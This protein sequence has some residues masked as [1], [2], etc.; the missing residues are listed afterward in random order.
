MKLAYP[1][2]RFS[3]DIQSHGDSARRQ[4]Q[5]V[6]NWA[7]QH[8]D[9]RLSETAYTDEGLSA[10][11]GKHASAELGRLMSDIENG[12]I[13]PSDCILI[14]SLDRL[15]REDIQTASERLKAIQVKGVDVVTLNDET[16][17]TVASLNDSFTLIKQI[18]ISQRAHEESEAKSKRMLQVW[19]EKRR[20]AEKSG[21]VI[22]RMCP[23]W[24]KANKDG[25]GFDVIH[26][27]VETL[28][29]M[30]QLRV[31]GLGFTRITQIL[32]ETGRLTFRDN[33]PNKWQQ[34]RVQQ[35]ISSRAVIGYHIKSRKSRV[36]EPEVPDYYPVV[37]PLE[38]FQAAQLRRESRFGRKPSN[39]RPGNIHLFK[40]VMKCACCGSAT[41][42]NSVTDTNYGYYTCS[43]KRT[44]RCTAINV[45][46]Q[47][48]D[49]SLVQGLLYNLDRFTV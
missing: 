32:N 1:Y 20:E 18:L 28:N 48:V 21:R 15:S 4:K 16:H 30:F 6:T 26:E 44:G 14:E 5:L 43:F 45:K 35:L 47:I 12:T 31:Q 2:I 25:T 17:Y 23:Q 42:L 33:L 7:N 9:Y 36:K 40:S 8:P 37:I 19:A 22:T 49:D 39:P 3:S 29:I 11:H 27:H 38:L 41:V 24:L 10:Y 34:S 13:R 46:R